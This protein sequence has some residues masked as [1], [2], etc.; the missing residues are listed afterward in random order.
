MGPD[1]KNLQHN[2]QII[3]NWFITITIVTKKVVLSCLSTEGSHGIAVAEV[4]E[5]SDSIIVS[6]FFF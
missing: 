6:K 5:A 2:R 4:M 3:G 1:Y